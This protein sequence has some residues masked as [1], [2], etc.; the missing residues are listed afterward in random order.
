MTAFSCVL[1]FRVLTVDLLWRGQRLCPPRLVI[2]RTRLTIQNNYPEVIQRW[3]G[4]VLSDVVTN[5]V[6]SVLIM[7]RYSIRLECLSF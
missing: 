2:Q 6:V 3:I 1:Y 5:N 4:Y 7:Y